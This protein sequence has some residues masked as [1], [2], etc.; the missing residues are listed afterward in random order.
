M[1]NMR[2]TYSTFMTNESVAQRLAIQWW[3]PISFPHAIS[4]NANR[5]GSKGKQNKA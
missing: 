3:S 1:A 2:Q 5:V 4:L